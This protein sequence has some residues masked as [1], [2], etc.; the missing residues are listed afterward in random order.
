MTEGVRLVG[1]H[2]TPPCYPPMLKPATLVQADLEASASWR[3]KAAVGR[4]HTSDPAHI[5]HLE[6]TAL[7]ELQLGS[8]KDL[9]SAKVK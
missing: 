9:S 4:S 7:E 6:A 1:T 8:L 3:R 5:E 2:D